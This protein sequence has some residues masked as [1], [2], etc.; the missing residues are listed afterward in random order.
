MLSILSRCLYDIGLDMRRVA[1]EMKG[2]I[3]TSVEQHCL[4]A[5]AILFQNMESAVEAYELHLKH[6]RDTTISVKINSSR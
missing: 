2:V 1:S 4:I 5:N 3:R 6:I